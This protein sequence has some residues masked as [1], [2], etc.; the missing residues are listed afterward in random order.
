LNTILDWAIYPERSTSSPQL[1]WGKEYNNLV[2]NPLVLFGGVKEGWEEEGLEVMKEL[3]E[4][5]T[6]DKVRLIM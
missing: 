1:E 6:G 2:P 5:F 4:L 3:N